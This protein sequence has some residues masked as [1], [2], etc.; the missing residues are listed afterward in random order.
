MSNDEEKLEIL[1]KR[2]RKHNYDI[3][4]AERNHLLSLIRRGTIK[5]DIAKDFTPDLLPDEDN[6]LND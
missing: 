1:L 4:T 2:L 5:I 3:D 6:D